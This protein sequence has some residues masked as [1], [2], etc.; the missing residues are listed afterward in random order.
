[1]SLSKAPATRIHTRSSSRRLEEPFEEQEGSQFSN[2]EYEHNGGPSSGNAGKNV[3]PIELPIAHLDD[4]G[5]NRVEG[6]SDE[7]REIQRLTQRVAELEL[8]KRSAT[9]SSLTNT[10]AESDINKELIRLIPNYNGTGGIQ[11]LLQFVNKVEDY[12]TN[13]NLGPEAEL[14]L[15]VAKLTDDA[16]MWWLEQQRT[17]PNDPKRI[18]GW[19][20]LKRGLRQEY[21]PAEN[22]EQLRVELLALKQTGSVAEYNTAFRRISLQMSDLESSEA[23]FLYKRGLKPRILDLV[24]TK[25]NISTVRE[26]QLACLKLDA[27]NTTGTKRTRDEEALVAAPTASKTARTSTRGRG[28]NR[29]KSR[30]SRGRGKAPDR[31]TMTCYLC[32]EKG[33]TMLKCPKRAEIVSAYKNSKPTALIAYEP[34]FID[35]GA[36]QH[37]FNSEAVFEDMAPTQAQINCAGTEQLR[38]THVGTVD[39][40]V[41][42]KL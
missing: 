19:E 6:E 42:G 17:A 21:V 35:S 24:L 8:E 28:S 15:A 1:M 4:V 22:D 39:S 2:D 14:R 12:V 16:A 11:K 26:L 29:G 31:S 30:G 36:S 41:T 38:A 33:H 37:M 10:R 20:G 7:T 25:D 9:P 23:K 40:G 13:T 18:T 27:P 32:E 34:T 5:Q 3:A